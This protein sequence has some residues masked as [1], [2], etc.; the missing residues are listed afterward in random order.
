MRFCGVLEILAPLLFLTAGT[1]AAEAPAAYSKHCVSCH[2]ADGSGRKTAAL[3]QV[4]DL[5]SKPISSLTDEQLYNAIARGDRHQA[6]PH[7]FQRLGLSESDLGQIVR[8]IREL[9]SSRK[10]RA[11]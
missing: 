9:Q 3:G 1:F 2:A 10:S 4:P 5:R 8:Y 7:S 11:H 6:Y